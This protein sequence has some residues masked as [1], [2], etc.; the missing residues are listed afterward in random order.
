MKKLI[1]LLIL[2][3]GVCLANEVADAEEDLDETEQIQDEAGFAPDLKFRCTSDDNMSACYQL[4]LAYLEGLNIK[5]NP[6]KAPQFFK[7]ACKQKYK[8]SCEKFAYSYTAIGEH[9]ENHAIKHIHKRSFIKAFKFYKKACSLK[10]P[11][12][13]YN[14]ALFFEN[15]KDGVCDQNDK[16]A[17]KFFKISCDGGYELACAKIK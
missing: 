11:Q 6:K 5:K 1:F 4:G 14:Y 17:Q 16:Q 8:D 7:I 10:D 13:C 2:S 15:G 9:Y 12:G 3:F